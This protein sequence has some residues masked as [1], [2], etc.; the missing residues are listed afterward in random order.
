MKEVKVKL[1]DGTICVGHEFDDRDYQE[2]K[3]IFKDWQAINERLKKLGGRTLNVPD[4]FSEGLFC[5]FFGAVRT[6]GTA[7]SYDCVSF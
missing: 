4:V 5:Y 2:L 6:N 1:T 3:E 7:Y